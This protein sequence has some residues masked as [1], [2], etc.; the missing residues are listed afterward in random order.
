V[1]VGKNTVE[2]VLALLVLVVLRVIDSLGKVV[3]VRVKR[4]VVVVEDGAV[5]LE[6]EMVVFVEIMV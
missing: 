3:E 1:S 2:L 5:V 4:L 6:L